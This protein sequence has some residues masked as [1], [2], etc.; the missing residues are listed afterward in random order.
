MNPS[1]TKAVRWQPAKLRGIAPVLLALASPGVL[2]AGAWPEAPPRSP[3]PLGS[4]QARAEAL[5]TV[6]DYR[7]AA[8]LYQAL[9]VGIVSGESESAT[10]TVKLARALIEQGRGESIAEHCRDLD[11]LPLDLRLLI[12]FESPGEAWS[13]EEHARWRDALTDEHGE[14]LYWRARLEMH[15]G[16][17]AAARQ[18]L[19]QLLR[20]EP[21]SIFVPAA[22]ELL[23]GLPAAGALPAPESKET[24]V[25]SGGVR[26]QWGVF[27]D[28]LRARRQ[29]EAVEA[30]GQSAEILAFS[31]DGI[32]LYRVY[33]PPFAVDIEAREMGE[34]LRRRYGLAFVLH[35]V[36]AAP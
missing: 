29:R 21:G 13:E 18:G 15:L 4:G 20:R 17:P 32:E 26:V 5:A 31:R 8:G 14:S 3:T 12:A 36:Q 7:Y 10:L 25:I 22:M 2:S 16:N 30:Y 27:R 33:S 35:R 1:E 28:P 34:A 9:E 11:A 24:A 23:E 6:S 19:R